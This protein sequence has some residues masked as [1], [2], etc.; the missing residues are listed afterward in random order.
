MILISLS[1]KDNL[2][3]ICLYMYLL[4]IILPPIFPKIQIFMI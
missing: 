2:G 4:I 1:M 3:L